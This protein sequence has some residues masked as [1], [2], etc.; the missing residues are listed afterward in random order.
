[1]KIWEGASHMQSQTERRSE[2]PDP[3]DAIGYIRFGM[4]LATRSDLQELRSEVQEGR[5][6]T[7]ELRGEVQ[8]LRGEVHLLGERVDGV[9]RRLDSVER[10]LDSLVEEVA[11]LRAA[12]KTAAWILAALI[13]AV[14]VAIAAI[15]L[16][17]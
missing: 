8:E 10:R 11:A 17:G 14:G 6:E 12:I 16:F 4:D 7:Q 13:S 1:M 2:T 3:G 5:S 9:E 15:Q